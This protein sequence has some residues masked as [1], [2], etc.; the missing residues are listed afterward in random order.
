MGSGRRR[1]LRQQRWRLHG[2]FI[3]AS[4]RAAAA[5]PD[6]GAT[7]LACHPAH[8]AQRRTP[9]SLHTPA[10]F[11][12]RIAPHGS[13]R[14]F[15][16]AEQCSAFPSLST[17]LKCSH[18]PAPSASIHAAAVYCGSCSFLRALLHGAHFGSLSSPHGCIASLHSAIIGS[19][20]RIDWHKFRCETATEKGPPSAATRRL[21]LFHWTVDVHKSAVAG[22]ELS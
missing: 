8:C 1:C 15:S 16:L 14:F 12:G 6:G 10:C 2:L 20:W 9:A 19:R 22:R 5:E 13:T 4:R 17:R 18:H 7:A 21:L 3:G 11:L